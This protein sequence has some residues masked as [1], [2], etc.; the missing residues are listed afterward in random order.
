MFTS[1]FSLT[2]D[3]H[4]SWV[5]RNRLWPEQRER[6]ESFLDREVGHQLAGAPQSSSAQPPPRAPRPQ[7]EG[8][9][10]G[11]PAAADL[12]ELIDELLD[13][14]HNLMR[15][16]IHHDFSDLG[17]DLSTELMSQLQAPSML[18]HQ[19][20]HANGAPRRCLLTLYELGYFEATPQVLYGLRPPEFSAW[21]MPEYFE[22]TIRQGT[23]KVNVGEMDHHHWNPLKIG[24]V[25]VLG[26]RVLLRPS[27][28]RGPGEGWFGT[29]GPR[30]R[31]CPPLAAL[32]QRAG[33]SPDR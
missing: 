33:C 20:R 26:V 5:R 32:P 15:L 10:A 17:L 14:A 29:L 9:P 8:T 1:V 3:T 23:H 19:C 27:F 16:R 21:T 28:L 7:P 12:E 6:F 25:D 18:G 11:L 22:F 30:T 4:H 2:D 13:P 24:F 31:K